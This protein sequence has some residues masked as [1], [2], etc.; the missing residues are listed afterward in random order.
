MNKHNNR[1]TKTLPELSVSIVSCR[2]FQGIDA[3][4]Y[5][6]YYKAYI[7][8]IN[9]TT[10]LVNMIVSCEQLSIITNKNCIYF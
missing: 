7:K 6:Y 3:A 4:T 2:G 8:S 5:K 1:Q 10:Q 9:Q